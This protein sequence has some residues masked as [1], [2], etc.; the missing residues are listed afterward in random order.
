MM[1]SERMIGRLA[2]LLV[3]LMCLYVLP[4]NWFHE[5]ET[6]H[7]ERSA[8]SASVV[9]SD[10][11]PVCEVLVHSYLAV[12]Q[13]RSEPA[14]KYIAHQPALAGSDHALKPFLNDPSRG[15]PSVFGRI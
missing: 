3:W 1:R 2:P 4:K 7:H 8:T 11:C 9:S 15:P 14:R 10:H 5:C 13:E 12:F 6:H